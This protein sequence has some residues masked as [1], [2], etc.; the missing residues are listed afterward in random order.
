MITM[1]EIIQKPNREC[2]HIVSTKTSAPGG[3]ILVVTVCGH[4]VFL[5][6]DNLDSYDGIEEVEGVTCIQ[7]RRTEE[8]DWDS[9]RKTES[10]RASTV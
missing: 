5:S 4:S 7:C 8:G 1:L 3:R 10:S 6:E 2:S 9:E